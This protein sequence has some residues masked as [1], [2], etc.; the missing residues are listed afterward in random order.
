MHRHI[1]ARTQHQ[2]R[3]LCLWVGEGNAKGNGIRQL[4]VHIEAYKNRETDSHFLEK[5]EREG[6]I[7]C[8]G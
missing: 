5:E 6:E 2:P 7:E 4:Q 8:E 1:S 3:L